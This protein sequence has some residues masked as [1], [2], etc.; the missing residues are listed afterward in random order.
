MYARPR[1]SVFTGSSVSSNS[2]RSGG[3]LPSARRR[4]RCDS[5]RRTNSAVGY[6]TISLRIGFVRVGWNR[7]ELRRD[8][9]GCV[10]LVE[11]PEKLVGLGVTFVLR[12][13][14]VP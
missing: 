5:R 6:W 2:R 11:R 13:E 7:L 4:A 8:E 9:I 3:I 1:S 10:Q 12:T 14:Q